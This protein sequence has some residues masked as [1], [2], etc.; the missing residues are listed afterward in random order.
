MKLLYFLGIISLYLIGC[1]FGD[2]QKTPEP[3][4]NINAID[5]S[6]N[7]CIGKYEGPEFINGEDIAHQFSNEMSRVVGDKLKDLYNEKNYSK[8]DLP[9]IKMTTIGMGTGYVIY[10]LE[11]PFISVQQ[12]CDAFTSFD[13]VGG[14]NH[15]PQLEKRIGELNTNLLRGEELNISNLKRTPEGLQEYWIQW[16]NKVAQEACE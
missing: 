16:K 9:K 11:I 5:C 14:W 15:T 13:H 8:V 10:G 3:V 1:N 2:K 7:G 12:E 6:N 4:Q